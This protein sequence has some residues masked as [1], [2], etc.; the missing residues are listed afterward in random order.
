MKIDPGSTAIGMASGAALLGFAVPLGSFMAEN[1]SGLCAATAV[2]LLSGSAWL[3][4]RT[5]SSTI[6]PVGFDLYDP[7]VPPS[8]WLASMGVMEGDPL[9][10]RLVEIGLEAQLKTT[11]LDDPRVEALLLCLLSSAPQDLAITI[12]RSSRSDMLSRLAEAMMDPDLK[13]GAVRFIEE[14]G[15]REDVRLGEIRDILSERHGTPVTMMLAA[16][17]AARCGRVSCAPSEFLWL[18]K[19][20]RRLWYAMSNLGRASFHIEGIAAIAHFREEKIHGRS[21]APLIGAALSALRGEC[22]DR[23]GS[24][25]EALPAAA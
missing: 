11:G 3:A 25:M 14:H 15:L 7:P 22:I 20:D 18:K 9:A 17:E 10:S 23:K 4:F 19:V 5:R 13:S 6:R 21:E 8:E 24:D 1:V 12:S 16:L 2:S